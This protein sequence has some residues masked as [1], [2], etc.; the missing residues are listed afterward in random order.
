MSNDPRRIIV[1]ESLCNRC[2]AHTI[3][4]HHQHF[5]ELQIEGMSVEQA[6]D[7]LADRM[8]A[9]FDAVSDPSRR[10]AV[11]SAIDDIRAFLNRQGAA[12]PARDIGI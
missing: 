4:V 12:H 10:E 1:T 7:H 11:Q 3:H 9:A 6:A 8:A 5:P 2:S